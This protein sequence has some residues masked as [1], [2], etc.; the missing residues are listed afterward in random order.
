MAN[1]QL[2][3]LC[4]AEDQVKKG[5]NF[6]RYFRYKMVNHMLSIYI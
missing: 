6:G 1:K 3:L 5:E 4:Q 2:S